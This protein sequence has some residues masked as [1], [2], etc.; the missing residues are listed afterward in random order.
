MNDRNRS[1]REIQ[2]APKSRSTVKQ[3]GPGGLKVIIA[4]LSAITVLITGV[5]YWT[6]GRVGSTLTSAGNLGLS[7]SSQGSGEQAPDGAVDI[8]LV[9]SD[10]RTDAHGNQLSRE[11]LERLNAG[12]F[13]GEDN[14]DTIMLIREIGR[15]SCRERV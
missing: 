1:S 2:P 11:E 13:A 10:S 9:G 14:T 12:E 5:G 3:R 6:V 15:A 4:L 8:L 7:D